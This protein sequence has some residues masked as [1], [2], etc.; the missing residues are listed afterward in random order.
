MIRPILNAR[1]DGAATL[2]SGASF[3]AAS[4]STVDLS[5]ATVTLPGANSIARVT[6]ANQ[7][8]RYAL[9]TASVQNGDYVYQ[10]DTTTL[11]EVTDQTALSG[12]SGYT[13]L[14]TVT[15]S[16]ITGLGTGVAA[17]LAINIGSAGA[18]IAFNGA[19]GTPSSGT[20][21]SCTGLPIS[22]GVSGLGTG[23]ATWL[24]TPS[25]AN[26]AAT[27]TGGTGSGALV[28]GTSPTLVTPALGTPSSA[29]LTSCTGLPISTGVSG[30]GTGVATFLATPSGA[31]LATALTSAIPITK[32]GTGGTTAYTAITG[33]GSVSP[34]GAL[35]LKDDFFTGT[36][37]AGSIGELGWTVYNV[38]GSG[39]GAYEVNSF[40]GA[41]K[42]TTGS[43]SG[44]CTQ[45][46]F[47]NSSAVNV[48]GVNAA[49]FEMWWRVKID[50]VTNVAAYLGFS[51]NQPVVTKVDN[52]G[53]GANDKGYWFRFDTSL[54]VADAQ[55]TLV[56]C[57]DATGT[58]GHV[59]SAAFT[60]SI[61]AGVYYTLKMRGDGTGAIYGTMYDST[62]T[63]VGS[64]ISVANTRS[65]SNGMFLIPQI[66]TKTS[67]TR[68]L[69]IDFFGLA[70]NPSR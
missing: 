66:T 61:S 59:L 11:Y 38:A 49:V 44:N 29:T 35:S 60:G 5:A 22:T 55:W 52:A 9:T 24:A 26:L 63:I 45:L 25:S 50:T 28:F 20:L 70:I 16:Q 56:T 46:Y 37:V 18:F 65:I 21:T 69:S 7:A 62:G 27:I 15:V 47:P 53:S 51:W 6:A 40:L 3:T 43:T 48:S 1:L 19:L 41:F 23:V 14:A 31:N 34:L 32:G 58:T 12:A 64:E 54:N 57:D 10:T 17:A 8:A 13:A 2:P 36:N 4:G 33:L 42:I 68:A 67:A 39:S 30:L